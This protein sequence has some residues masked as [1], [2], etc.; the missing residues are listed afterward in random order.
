[1]SVGIW[2]CLVA[3][4]GWDMRVSSVVEDTC[5]QTTPAKS[6]NT[7]RS[8]GSRIASRQTSMSRKLLWFCKQHEAM[9]DKLQSEKMGLKESGLAPTRTLRKVKMATSQSCVEQLKEL[10]RVV[11][12]GVI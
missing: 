12:L 6:L 5:D 4:G 8:W 10:K 7:W 9:Y 1:M 11:R 2:V 3:I